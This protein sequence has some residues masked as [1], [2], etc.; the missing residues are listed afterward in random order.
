MGGP[1]SR[2][3]RI[4]LKAAHRRPRRIDFDEEE[5]EEEVNPGARGMRRKG[6]PSWGRRLE[7]EKRKFKD[8]MGK[9]IV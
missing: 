8:M 1:K 3:P 2:P 5:E 4:S 6:R 7:K 9:G